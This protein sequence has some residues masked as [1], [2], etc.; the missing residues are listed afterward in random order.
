MINP[1]DENFIKNDPR[2]GLSGGERMPSDFQGEH[3]GDVISGEGRTGR[4]AW[5]ETRDK[6]AVARERTEFF[7]R[8][9]PVP[10]I[11]GALAAGLAIGLA[12]RYS[13]Q[14]EQKSLASRLPLAD[15]DWS[16]VSLP[17]LWP[18]FKS[19]KRRYEDGADALRDGVD[20][21]KDVDVR[22]YTKPM[23]KRWEAWTN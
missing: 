13:S 9:N 19:V 3:A 6:M 1:N 21:V 14:H 11:L 10:M 4:T 22:R 17:F 16:W 5:D 2:S 7:L 20:R 23:R 12:I 8:E 18:F 15:A